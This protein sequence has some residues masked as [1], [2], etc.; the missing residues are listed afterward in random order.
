MPGSVF[1]SILL[2]LWKPINFIAAHTTVE[3][4]SGK[5]ELVKEP[6][7][8]SRQSVSCRAHKASPGGL[9]GEIISAVAEI[10]VA[11]G[12]FMLR[13]CASTSRVAANIGVSAR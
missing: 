6:T 2:L 4:H 7:A 13:K 12:I 8:V 3:H 9:V 5:S 1:A 10:L 11:T